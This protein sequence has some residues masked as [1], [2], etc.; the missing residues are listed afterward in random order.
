MVLALVVGPPQLRVGVGR[1][2]PR[3]FAVVFNLV[4]GGVAIGAA[5]LDLLRDFD[6]CV[7]W[8]YLVMVGCR[9]LGLVFVTIDEHP[10][11]AHDES[12]FGCIQFSGIIRPRPLV[13]VV[14]FLRV[15]I[16]G[17]CGSHDLRVK[18]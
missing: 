10:R 11:L 6:Y 7:L 18:V 12:R 2:V 5:N 16:H 13:K 14:G 8:C 1:F 17:A 9:Y 4:D 3:T 15:V